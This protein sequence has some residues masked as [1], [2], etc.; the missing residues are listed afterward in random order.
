MI[1]CVGDDGQSSRG[2]M[3][4]LRHRVAGAMRAMHVLRATQVLAADGV[5][6][7]LVGRIDL[8]TSFATPRRRRSL[9]ERRRGQTKVRVRRGTVNRGTI[10]TKGIG[11]C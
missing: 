5:Q 10:E 9:Q 6:R 3:L 1:R 4:S 2:S 8:G 7:M 11:S